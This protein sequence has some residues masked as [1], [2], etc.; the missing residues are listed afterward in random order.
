MK[1]IWSQNYVIDDTLDNDTLNNN[2]DSNDN[3]DNN[4]NN[5][6]NNNDNNWDNLYN[7]S[8]DQ[9]IT[10]GGQSAKK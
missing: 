9:T 8:G 4:N 1:Q 5:N 6:N 3:N 2:N 7:D 10:V